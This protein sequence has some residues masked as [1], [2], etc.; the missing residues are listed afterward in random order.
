MIDELI[1]YIILNYGPIKSK[2][3]FQ[4]IFYFLTEMGIPTN[5]KYSL[6]HYGPYSS[7]LESKSKELDT[8]DVICIEKLSKM[9]IISQGNFTEEKANS[10]ELEKFTRDVDSII[11]KLP[12][13]SPLKLELYSTTHYVNSVIKKIYSENSISA[14]VEEVKNIKQDKFTESEIIEAYNYLSEIRFI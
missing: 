3:A 2:K 6:Y 10:K 1:A 13:D 12:L 4:K 7:D 9:Y 11:N 14:V 8:L 5:L